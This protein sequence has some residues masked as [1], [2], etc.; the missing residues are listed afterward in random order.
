MFLSW[1]QHMLQ[2]PS[3]WSPRQ[4]RPVRARSA[5]ITV[6][7]LEDRNLLSFIMDPSVPAGTNAAGVALGNLFNNGV[8]DLAVTNNHNGEANGTVMIFKNT[9]ATIGGPISYVMTQEI[10]VGQEPVG[11]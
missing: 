2:R 3:R 5:R 7:M 8:L 9:T 11:V 10:N 6:E 4:G 1:C